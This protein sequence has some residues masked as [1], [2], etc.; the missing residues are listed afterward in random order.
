MNAIPGS[1]FIIP[2][3][4]QRTSAQEPQAT[5]TPENP[6]S[7][8]LT[9]AQ[10]A[11]QTLQEAAEQEGPSSA[12][13]NELT[14]E[15]ER[16]V[17]EL[18]QTD[19]EVRAHEQ[20][21]KTIAGPYAGAISYQTVTG[22]DGRQYAVAGEVDIDVSPI[23]N[24]PEA[25]IRKM[26]IVIR[27]ALAPAEPS[28]QDQAVAR[29]AQ[30]TRAQAQRELQEQRQTEREESGE[31]QENPLDITEFDPN[32]PT[33]EQKQQISA[34]IQGLN[35]AEQLTENVTGTLFDAIN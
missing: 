10:R 29:A 25:T 30:Q 17:E 26:D 31:S 2:Q 19:R 34:L 7:E 22:P 27:A 1:P 5:A 11:L 28:P 15:E 12:L 3:Q 14:E 20:A 4:F 6:E 35:N 9:D 23:P 18:K 13:D 24:N 32:N 21:H 16:I 33:E 8:E